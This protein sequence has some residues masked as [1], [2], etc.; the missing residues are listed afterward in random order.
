[1]HLCSAKFD[2]NAEDNPMETLDELKSFLKSINNKN[3]YEMFSIDEA[4]IAF[5]ISK[6]RITRALNEKEIPE[7]C[8][9]NRERMIKRRDMEKWIDS[10]QKIEI[11]LF[12][13]KNY[14]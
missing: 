1:M 14:S 5:N 4:A 13:S 6:K 7:F 11:P 3:P 8:M 12:R 2:E 10:K 9:D